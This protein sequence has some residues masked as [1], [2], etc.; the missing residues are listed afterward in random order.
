MDYIK[1]RTIN[2]Q[3]HIACR[4]WIDSQITA[5]WFL[6]KKV[7][8]HVKNMDKIKL[9]IEHDNKHIFASNYCYH[10]HFWLLLLF[11]A[12]RGHNWIF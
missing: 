2:M 12:N 11:L 1:R 5:I 4:M 10:H 7:Y 9:F 8:L 6:N 3:I